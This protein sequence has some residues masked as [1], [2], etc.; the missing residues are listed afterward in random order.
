MT[1]AERLGQLTVPHLVLVT[2]RSRLRG[3]A[4]AAVVRRGVEGGVTAV[5]LRDRDAT[6]EELLAMGAQIRQAISGR[7]LFFVN[8]D[9]EAAI[10]LGAN[11]V[12]LPEAAGPIAEV[13]ERVG[14]HMLISRAVHSI[15]AAVRAEEDEAD[16]VQLGT[17]FETASK[18]GAPALGVEGV[19]A[20]CAALRIPV[21][22][23]GGITP[24]NVGGVLRAGAA[25]VTVIGAV[26]DADDPRAAA[27]ALSEAMRITAPVRR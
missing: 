17:V 23:I 21:I 18:P 6:R 24:T 3:R 2:D 25:G 4:L 20:A 9:I 26:F 16:I 10:S 7:A 8:S 15:D 5:Q 11:G 13:R 22:A 19:R 27:Q 14:E 1:R 12:H